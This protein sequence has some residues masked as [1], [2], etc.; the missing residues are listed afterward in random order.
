MDIVVIFQ[1]L[2]ANV[3]VGDAVAGWWHL[4]DKNYGFVVPIQHLPVSDELKS[5]LMLWRFRKGRD[6]L[7][8]LQNHN[9]S[10]LYDECHDLEENILCELNTNQC[11]KKGPYPATREHVAAFLS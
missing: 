3:E 2:Y 5:R 10:V 8:S 4:R 1:P 7:R 6:L 9:E 11:T